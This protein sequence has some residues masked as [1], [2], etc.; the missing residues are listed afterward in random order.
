MNR[1][2]PASGTVLAPKLLLQVNN[3]PKQ[4]IA[5]GRIANLEESVLKSD[6]SCFNFK[7][8]LLKYFIAL[9]VVTAGVLSGY[10]SMMPS[11]PEEISSTGHRMVLDTS[12]TT[13]QYLARID[14][15]NLASSTDIVDILK[16]NPALLCPVKT[17]NS[18]DS[19]G[20]GAADLNADDGGS[21]LG[22]RGRN[23]VCPTRVVIQR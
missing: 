3:C 21:M 19:M 23:N 15:S 7:K 14:T 8:T 13:S 1:R 9:C 5:A 12:A 10:A 2:F 20:N 17:A 16:E 6:N 11:E 22:L 18:I 4:A